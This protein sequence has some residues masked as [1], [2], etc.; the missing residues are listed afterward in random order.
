MAAAATRML[1]DLARGDEPLPQDRLELAT[2]LIVRGSTG[3][4]S[5]EPMRA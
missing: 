4:L 1:I 2:K 3:S 5:V